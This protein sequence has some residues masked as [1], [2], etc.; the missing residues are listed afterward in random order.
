MTVRHSDHS[1]YTGSMAKLMEQ[2]ARLPGIG[3]K[4]AE[5]L[6]YHIMRVS[7]EEAMELAYAIRDIKRNVRQCSKC[8]HMSESDPCPICGDPT[9]D[10]EVL[11][12]VEQP[13]DVVMIEQTRKYNGLYHVLTGRIAPLEG[14]GPEDLTVPE[15]CRRVSRMKI[16][17]VILATNPDL[18]GDGTALFVCEALKLTGV[19]VT[20]IARGIPTGTLIEYASKTIL[21]DALEG[22]REMGPDSGETGRSDRPGDVDA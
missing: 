8:F 17:E 7:T 9:R 6:A 14:S 18:E 4:S 5:R 21:G 11:C 3:A 22:R 1:G 16:Q 20:K 15:L 10:Q 19:K 2:F 13:K 12:V